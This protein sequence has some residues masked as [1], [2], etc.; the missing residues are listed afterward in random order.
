[1]IREKVMKIRER[2]ICEA[3]DIASQ[4][5]RLSMCE[6]EALGKLVDI[7]KD[8]FEM[9]KT[10]MEIEVLAENERAKRCELNPHA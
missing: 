6:I 2:A 10:A 9:N 3:Y 7:V 4:P 5:C 1:M 8:T